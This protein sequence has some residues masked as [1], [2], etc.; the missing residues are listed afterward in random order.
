M[1]VVRLVVQCKQGGPAIRKLPQPWIYTGAIDRQQRSTEYTRQLL[2][3]IAESMRMPL[4]ESLRLHVYVCSMRHAWL[5]DRL[6]QDMLHV[7]HL[8]ESWIGAAARRTKYSA[9][10]WYYCCKEQRGRMRTLH[11]TGSVWRSAGAAWTTLPLL[12]TC[13]RRKN[14]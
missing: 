3:G 8:S 2:S 11:A 6:R 4:Q 13:T 5:R 1:E 7:I 14:G 9:D 10:M 12:Y